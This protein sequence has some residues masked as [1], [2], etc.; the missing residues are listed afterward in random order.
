MP[1]PAIIR[2]VLREIDALHLPART[3]IL[4]LSCGEGE[5]LEQLHSRGFE[6]EG[7]HYRENDYILRNPS[8]ILQKAVIHS[9]VDLTVPLPF[10]DASFDVVLATEVLEHLPS[11]TGILREIGRILSPDGV[12]LFTTPNTHRTLSRLQFLFTGTHALNGARLGWHT[13]ADEVY[14]THYN[15]VYFP[16]IHA[17]LFQN[18]LQIESLG[19]SSSRPAGWILTLL[20]WPLTVLPVWMETLHFCKRSAPGGRNLRKWLLHP[21]LFLSKQLVVVSRHNSM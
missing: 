1:E 11:H 6:A 15:P 12:F 5:I 8:P 13:P 4:D 3:R 9:S 14:S 19:F 16:V 2:S 18:R 10:D 21:S 17:L 7:T 20:L